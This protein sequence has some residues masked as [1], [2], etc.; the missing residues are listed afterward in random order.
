MFSTLNNIINFG[1][2][3]GFSILLAF[4]ADCLIAPAILKESIEKY[5]IFEKYNILSH[6]ENIL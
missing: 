6:K 3:T 5:N 4:I 2:L 1:F